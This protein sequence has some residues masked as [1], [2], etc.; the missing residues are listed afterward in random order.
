[1]LTLPRLIQQVSL[2]ENFHYGF[3]MPAFYFIAALLISLFS[4]TSMAADTQ[5]KIG[6]GAYGMKLKHTPAGLPNN[7]FGGS[8]FAEHTQNN[9]AGSRFVI[10]NIDNDEVSA[11]GVEAQLLLGYGLAQNGLRLYTGP[12]WHMEHMHLPRNGSTNSSTLKG[13]AWQVG[14]GVQYKSVSLDYAF[15]LRANQAYKKE[16]RRVGNPNGN[17]HTHS[18]LLGYRF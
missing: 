2:T 12:T 3:N 4:H 1:M 8:I 18:I 15:G 17:M 6:V 11:H 9:Y 14:T 16:N 5:L 13:W 10:Y 7:D